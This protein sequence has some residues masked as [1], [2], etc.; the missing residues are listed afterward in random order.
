MACHFKQDALPLSS[1]ELGRAQAVV[2]SIR[3]IRPS[4]AAC[5][6]CEIRG[7]CPSP[8]GTI[9]LL[10]R[11]K[12][13]VSS[14]PAMRVLIVDD[15]E[16]VRRAVRS[17]LSVAPECEICGEAVN[18]EDAV[19]KTGQLT[20]DVIVM[21]ISMPKL[22]GLEATRQIRRLFPQTEVLML[23]Q[24]E[25][26][27]MVRQA[28]NAGARGYVVKGSI[29]RDLVT[30]VETV[31]RH[32]PFFDTTVSGQQ[33]RESPVSTQ[34]IVQRSAALEQAL[35]ESEELYRST[36]ELAAIGVAHLGLDGRFLRVNK[37]FGEIL[38][39]TPSELNNL[40]Y[41]DVTHPGDLNAEN[42][43]LHAVLAGESEQSSSERRYI[44]SDGSTVWVKR[45]L[46]SIH[47]ADRKPKHFISVI[48]DVSEQKEA[49]FAK[50][51][52][53][54]IVES[55]D[56]A[57]ISKDLNGVITSWNAGAQRI[58]GYTP[59]EAVGRPI[60]LII[61]PEL[62]DEEKEILR[63]LRAGQ[64]IEHFETVRVSKFGQRLNISLT[65]SPV[66]DARGTIIGASKI[67]RD[68]T[69]R[70]QAEALLNESQERFRLAQAA[71]QIGTWEWDP[72]RNTSSLS[73]E[74]HRMFG[75]T[76]AGNHREKWYS[77]L[78][79]EDRERVVAAI[80]D[81]QRT[82]SM[83][84]EYRYLHPSSGL[85]WFFCKGRRLSPQDSRMFGVLLDITERKRSAKALRE[86]EERTR[87]SLEAAGVGTWE[88]NIATGEVHWSE[89]M[90]R[91]HGQASG[92]F[93]G[94][95][96]SFLENV[97]PDDR[98]RIPQL[99]QQAISG[100]GK[101]YVEYRQIRA[102]GTLGWMEGHGQVRYDA[103]GKPTSMVGVCMDITKRKEAEMAQQEL[104]ERLE[105]RVRE[106]TRDLQ[107]KNAELQRHGELVR[108]LS[109]RLM[110]SQD[111]ERRRIARELHDSAGQIVTALQLNLQPIETKIE[112]VA[113]DAARA[114][115]ESLALVS[116]LSQELR[117]ISHLLHPPLL[118]EAG[119][120]SALRWYV[121]GYA[122][123]SKIAVDLKL[124]PDLGRLS[125]E[126]ET[127]IFRM[128]QECLTNIHRH[129]ESPSATIR[130]DRLP[131]EVRIEV[132]D[133]GKGIRL[134]PRSEPLRPGVGIQGMRERIHQL[135][136]QL[137][138]R[139]ETKG[140]S[141]IAVI[142]NQETSASESA[143]VENGIAV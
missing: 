120:A 25:S 109:A 12:G 29:G 52:L 88:W 97:H 64:R 91:V 79:P 61:P 46:S 77:R 35:R 118:D 1:R 143:P 39:Y 110:Q 123:R 131:T 107:E 92:S 5:I 2:Y 102:D 6:A 53:A 47:D 41:Q 40:K 73:S 85:R 15:H 84:L 75:T 86:A 59:E 136:G 81:G 18:G 24:H 112:S 117:T 62:H 45:T 106:R 94:T 101:Y 11:S 99:V 114:V 31:G 63:R 138:I 130:V 3:C 51:R 50:F 9:A 119:L 98:Q 26:Y 33:Q 132:R 83:E 56:D 133:Q 76:P 32:E 78:H 22:N 96:E 10:A 71:A 87:F 95:F 8:W 7:K 113:P 66:R 49:E 68:I 121:E 100:D 38:G 93:R 82:G 72:E 80:E 104:R 37:K 44:R 124:S 20:P 13:S 139:R 58:F 57:I 129:S 70:K 69:E 28:I 103:A 135:G 30:A 27:E 142:P 65:V 19:A 111:E 4:C 55:S 34:Q 89:N 17:L 140:T 134:G 48:E 125:R 60:T 141:V 23:S 108:Q 116:Q 43:E 67:A 16:I 42:V 122:D 126:M 54:A 14:V 115:R 74:L 90:E 137:E 36:F 127:A 105:E 21:D 128:V